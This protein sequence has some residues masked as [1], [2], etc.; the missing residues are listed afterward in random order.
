VIERT[1]HVLL[2][3]EGAD[4]FAVE[5]GSKPVEQ[6]YFFT[7]RRFRELNEA[8]AKQ[9]LPPLIKPA[10][11]M[12]RGA[13]GAKDEGGLRTKGTVGCVALDSHGNLAAATSTGGVNGKRPGRVGDSP[14]IGAGTYANR[15][16]AVSC[17]GTGEQFIRHSIATRVAML[18]EERKLSVDQAARICIDDILQPGDGGLIAVDRNG[19]F[20]LRSSTGGMPRAIADSTGRMEI[21]IWFDTK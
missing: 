14:I 20:S 12:S 16:C 17:T 11:K 10:Y 15:T 5:C 1:P 3:G 6:E 8:L 13:E 7:E 21:G 18:M 2:V 9:K 4:A 19:Q